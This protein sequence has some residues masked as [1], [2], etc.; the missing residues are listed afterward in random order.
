MKP[1]LLLSAALLLGAA[2]LA[3]AQNQVLELDGKAAYVQ[4]PGSSFDHLE[5]AT[6]EA[7]VRWDEWSPFSQWFAA[8]IDQGWRAMG[9]NHFDA[10][11]VLQFFIYTGKE[12]VQVLPVSA[13]LALGQWCHLAAVTGKEGMRFYLNGVLVAENAYPGSFAVLGG[14][15]DT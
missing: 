7:W 4:L 12:Q 3:R 13:S 9:I 11:A 2:C 6:V 14:T 15:P 8:G 5:E 10:S 1:L